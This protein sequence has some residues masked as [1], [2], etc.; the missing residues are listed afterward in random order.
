MGINEFKY[1][2]NYVVP[3]E[4]VDVYFKIFVTEAKDYDPM[5]II[6]DLLTVIGI[7]EKTDILAIFLGFLAI[8][9]L[10]II[11]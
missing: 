4:T 3:I 5:D 8:S 10:F 2:S 11:S 1:R 6:L 7:K 9:S